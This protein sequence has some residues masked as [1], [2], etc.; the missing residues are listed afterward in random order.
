MKKIVIINCVA[1]LALTLCGCNFLKPVKAASAE[2]IVTS[3]AFCEQRGEIQTF[4][5]AI[6]VNTE[7]TETSK[8][9]KIFE[10]S[11]K[12][13]EAAV[14]D[15]AHSLTQGLLFGHMAAIV[16]EESLSP[17]NFYGALQY[18]YSIEEI[19]LSALCFSSDDAK[20]LIESEPLSSV[21]VGYDILSVLEQRQDEYGT[22]F[23]NKLYQV[24]SLSKETL[25]TVA[26]PSF[27]AEDSLD[28]RGLSVY[29]SGK[30]VALLEN[31]QMSCYF[32][33]CD[34]QDKG[35][36]FIDGTLYEIESC[37][38]RRF[39]EEGRL[40]ISI[41]LKGDS[42]PLER[43]QKYIEETFNDSKKAGYDVFGLMNTFYKQESDSE[44]DTLLKKYKNTSFKV[45]LK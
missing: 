15:A 29:S 25:Q 43:I 5:E 7:N 2:Y 12:T 27:S 20:S 4:I 38:T 3:M 1:A 40:R 18:C 22:N 24:L 34:L 28:F 6:V 13:A 10:G 26:L 14:E 33:A 45:V 8:L 31:E 21:A 35:K 17:Q 23:K 9:R 44:Y 30:A 42:L 16:F 19:T 36:I 32:V 41:N 37:S 39:F 11:G